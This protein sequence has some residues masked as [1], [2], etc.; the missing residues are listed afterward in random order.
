MVVGAVAGQVTLIGYM[1]IRKGIKQ[2]PFLLPL[3]V[4]VLYL[5][6]RWVDPDFFFYFVVVGRCVRVVVVV[7]VMGVVLFV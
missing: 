1:L 6:S 3:P 4:L 7:V 2:W 5:S